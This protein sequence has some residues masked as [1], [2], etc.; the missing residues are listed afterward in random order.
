MELGL[1]GRTVLI[2]GG[3]KGIGLAC[4]RAFAA[5]GC[6]LVLVARDAQTLAE[7][8]ATLEREHEVR[9]RTHAVDLRN[10]ELRAELAARCQDV[11]ILVNNAGDIPMGS[12]EA[13]GAEAW[14]SAWELKLFGTIDLTRS[15]LAPMRS[16]GAGVIVNVIGMSAL[17]PSYDYVC[18]ATANAALHAF[19]RGIGMGSKAYGVRV[20]G[21]LPPA[22]RTDRLE[23]VMKQLALA[24]YGDESQTERLLEE[25]VWPVPIEPSQVAD[26]V[27]FLASDKAR[28]LSGVVLNLGS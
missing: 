18:G 3:S 23:Q 6:H 10:P 11:D 26:A 21:V 4:A 14:R 5:E 27:V 19:T 25:R 13:V 12:I 2:T 9:V 1:N 8:A 16:R 17:N 28:E 7:R 22:T 24:R 20:L 15:M